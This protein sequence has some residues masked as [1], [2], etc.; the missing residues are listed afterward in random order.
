MV[1]LEI[2]E[3]SYRFGGFLLCSELV[4]DKIKII[5]FQVTFQLLTNRFSIVCTGFVTFYVDL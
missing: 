2:K 1:S 5:F 4:V 3:V